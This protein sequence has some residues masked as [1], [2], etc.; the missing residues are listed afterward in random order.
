MTTTEPCLGLYKALYSYAAQGEDEVSVDED[1]LVFLLDTSDEEYVLYQFQ[2]N[3][4]EIH[5]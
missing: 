4:K 3:N 2:N 1:Q 5:R